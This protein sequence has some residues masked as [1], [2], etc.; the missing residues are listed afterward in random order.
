L[1]LP[2]YFSCSSSCLLGN[3]WMLITNKT[4]NSIQN[5]DHPAKPVLSSSRFQE[6][7]VSSMNHSRCIV[8]LVLSID[9]WTYEICQSWYCRLF[10]YQSGI[11]SGSSLKLSYQP[12]P[13]IGSKID[14][15]LVC[16]TYMVGSETVV[17]LVR[18]WY[19]LG[20][21]SV[22]WWNLKNWAH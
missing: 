7:N 1:F 14:F 15:W 2:A 10:T 18:G 17:K 22:Q 3:L 11:H 13:S 21:Q 4:I 12:G 6:G 19:Y 8:G 9:L 16:N 20:F 5:L